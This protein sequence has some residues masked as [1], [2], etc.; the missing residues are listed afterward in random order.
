MLT[1]VS[2]NRST[3]GKT[4]TS[5]LPAYDFSSLSDRALDTML[6]IVGN[7]LDASGTVY[8]PNRDR[9]LA[10][11]AALTAEAERRDAAL[12]E[13]LSKGVEAGTFSVFDPAL[14]LAQFA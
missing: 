12:I 8:G 3:E 10:K 5:S 2:T 9:L 6:R 14:G 7:V 11:E 13:A 4:M 1:Y